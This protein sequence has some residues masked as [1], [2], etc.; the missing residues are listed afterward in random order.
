VAAH[1]DRRSYTLP[2]DVLVAGRSCVVVVK[3]LSAALDGSG[4][5]YLLTITKLVTVF[6]TFDSESDALHSFN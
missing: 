6:E 2:P 4:R 1:H 5:L 3:R